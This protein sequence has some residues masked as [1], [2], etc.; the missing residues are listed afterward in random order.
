MLRKSLPR[1]ALP[2]FLGAVACSDGAGPRLPP[3][4]AAGF[5]VNLSVAQYVSIDP[6]PNSGCVVFPANASPTDSAE[7]LVMPQLATGVPGQTAGFRLLGDTIRPAVPGPPTSARMLAELPPAERFHTFLR[8]GDESRWRELDPRV[9]AER[10][11]APSRSAAEAAGPPAMGSSRS[12]RVCAKID[13]SRFDN[14]RATVRA[15]ANKVAIYVDTA[16]PPGLDSTELDSLAT[17]FGDKLYAVDTAAF[18]RESDID[19]NGVV[20]VLMTPTVNKMVTSQECS[21]TGYVSGFFLGVDLDPLFRND[22]RSNKGEVFYSLVVD[23]SGTLSCPHPVDGPNG[24]KPNLPVTIVHEFQHMI[25]YNQHVLVAGGSGEVLWL[26]EGFSHY[27]EELGGRSFIPGTSEDSATYSWFV[28]GDLSDAYSFLDSTYAHFLLP[29]AGIGSLAERGAAWL[30]V[31]YTVDQYAADTSRDARNAFTRSL[32][33]TSLTGAQNVATHTGDSFQTVVS[34]WALANYASHLPVSGFTAPPELRYVSWNFRTTYS[35]LHN[36]QGARYTKVFPLT[37]T[38]SA[39][40]SVDLSGT[41]HAGSGTYH[42][43]LQPPSG[44][45]FTLLFS[46]SSGGR[47][48]PGRF[49]RLNV[50]RIR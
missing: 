21:T 31:R 2:L 7:Y 9:E 30:F 40:R 15:L 4:T 29:T 42:R 47:L 10:L 17:V 38:V 33:A 20:L 1:L 5:A 43:I 8:L 23:P 3:C 36:T 26:N 48:D 32:L 18:G 45:G 12:F 34:R 19:T 39:G 49:P 25:S 27:A 41:L 50:I 11:N 44:A 35:F 14:V 6:T 46:S 16:A 28:R 13:C 22:A 37:P 24:V